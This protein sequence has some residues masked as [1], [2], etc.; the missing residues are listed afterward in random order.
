MRIKIECSLKDEIITTSYNR[1]ILSFIKKSLELYDKE[2]E[3]IYYDNSCIKDMSFACYLPI[4]KIEKEKI[5]LKEKNFKLFLTF[6]SVIDGIH[7]YNSF[8]NAKNKKI[9]FKINENIFI[10]T[11]ITKLQEKIIKDN[12]AIFQTLSPIIIKEK[13]EREREWFHILD[14]KGIE[15]LKKNICYSLKDKFSKV[16]LENL[17]IIPIDMKKTVVN[18]YDIKF[19]VTKG[20]FAIKGDKEVLDHF[21]KSGIGSKKSS[22]FGMLEL[23]K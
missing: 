22:G 9:E 23:V 8:I 17:E 15:V 1:K 16:K 11:K 19:P 10:V 14:K 3:K 5:Y 21:Y 4:E 20:I 12:T 7:Y 13:I 18:F 6:N 2:I